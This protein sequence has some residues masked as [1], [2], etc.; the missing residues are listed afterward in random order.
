MKNKSIKTWKTQKKR[1]KKRKLIQKFKNYQKNHKN[2][3]KNSNKKNLQNKSSNKNNNCLNNK[4]NQ[5]KVHNKN[6]KTIKLKNKSRKPQKNPIKLQ[7]TLSIT[8]PTLQTNPRILL[9][10]KW[11]SRIQINK[12]TTILISLAKRSINQLF[13]KKMNQARKIRAKAIKSRIKNNSSEKICIVNSICL[14]GNE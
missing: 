4:N 8:N 12:I 3:N 5:N 13:Q 2:M 7:Q 11:K 10:K 14:K 1:F 9:N 6:V